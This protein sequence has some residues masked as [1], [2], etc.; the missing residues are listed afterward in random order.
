MEA[1]TVTD[2]VESIKQIKMTEEE[3]APRMDEDKLDFE[4][5]DAE[6]VFE[7]FWDNFSA[8]LKCLD[9]FSSRQISKLKC[10]QCEF[11]SFKNID[12]WKN[13]VIGH[14]R[15]AGMTTDFEVQALLEYFNGMDF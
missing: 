13:H 10:S 4:G 3:P 5:P 2:P 12:Q 9:C 7:C 6:E 1:R 8:V 14:W 11:L 15:L